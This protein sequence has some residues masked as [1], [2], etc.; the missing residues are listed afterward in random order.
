MYSDFELE[1][2]NTDY[3]FVNTFLKKYNN[4]DYIQFDY[5]IVHDANLFLSHENYDFMRLEATLDEIIKAMGAIKRIFA[6]PIIRLKDS[7]ELLPIENVRI[8]N[9]SSIV[10]AASHADLWDD[11]TE[12]GIKPKKLLTYNNQDNYAIYEN[13]VFVMGINKILSFVKKNMRILKDFVYINE[14]MEGK[15]RYHHIDYFLAIGKLQ[16]G[17][18]RNTDRY[19][20]TTLRCINKMNFIYATI[21]ARL[22]NP[23]YKRVK[24]KNHKLDL[25]KTNIFKHHKDYKKIYHLLKFFEDEEIKYHK[26]EF[27]FETNYF[28]FLELI[29][30][31]SISHFNFKP[32][33]KQ[34][35]DFYNFD[36]NFRFKKWKLNL[37]QSSYKDKKVLLLKVKADYEYRILIYPMAKFEDNFKL[38]DVDYRSEDKVI[39]SLDESEKTTYISLTDIH[40]FQRIQQLILKAMI[41]TDKTR[42]ICP[43][44]GNELVKVKDSTHPSHVCNVCRNEIIEFNCKTIKKKYYATR[45]QNFVNQV[46]NDNKLPYSVKKENLMYYRNI[47]KIDD[48]LNI[49]CP[50]CHKIHN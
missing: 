39:F 38:E 3:E 41:Y 50:Y 32:E 13:V 37:R 11:I 21:K 7:M 26:D 24:V 4:L 46:D 25:K 2:L 31:F 36:V 15:K 16:S 9:N 40:S 29:T 17:Y 42:D 14:D 18:L 49:I 10:H 20:N 45:I 35:F 6:R 1:Q 48:Q 12:E 28:H 43:F 47:T 44:C 22:V 34:K 27:T 23:V 19:Y 33:E 5:H 30:V 8:I